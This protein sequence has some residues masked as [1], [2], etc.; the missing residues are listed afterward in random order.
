MER[1]DRR[2]AGGHPRFEWN[3]SPVARARDICHPSL[4]VQTSSTETTSSATLIGLLADEER[5]RVVAA[6]ALGAR[7]I[8]AAAAAAATDVATVQ[9][10]LPRLV[11]AGLVEQRDGLRVSLEALR[12]AARDRP[13]G[14]RDLPDATADQQRVLRNFVEDGRL[15]RLPARQGQ[16]RVILE[17]VAGRFDTDRQYA[18]AEVNELLTPLHDDHVALRRYLVDEGLLERQGGVYR[19]A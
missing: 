1:H 5:L 18:E 3:A 11:S 6:I 7:T 12:A 8:E 9:S 19:R 4:I 15:M 2:R 13:A 10:V 14:R 17:Y 16:R